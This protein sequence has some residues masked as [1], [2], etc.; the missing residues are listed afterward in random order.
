M[1]R[2]SQGSIE[3]LHLCFYTREERFAR[4]YSI[5]KG[6]A[7][8]VI[9]VLA[10]NLDLFEWIQITTVGEV[11]FNTSTWRISSFAFGLK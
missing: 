8:F 11:I 3:M 7:S 4:A 10:R 6:L 1:E 5:T 9:L 2:S